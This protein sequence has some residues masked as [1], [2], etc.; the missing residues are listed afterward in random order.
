MAKGQGQVQTDFKQSL[1]NDISIMSCTIFHKPHIAKFLKF[2]TNMIIRP[3][4]AWQNKQNDCAPSED[5]EQPGC[6][7]SLI[8]A[9]AVRSMG[10]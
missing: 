6:P 3:A 1:V 2:I 9:F 5:S 8:R 4:A 10:S 7:P